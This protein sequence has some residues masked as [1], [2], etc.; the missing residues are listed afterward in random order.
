MCGVEGDASGDKTDDGRRC[1]NPQVSDTVEAF[2]TV[3]LTGK[4]T[5]GETVTDFDNLLEQ[6]VNTAV[7]VDLNRPLLWE[8][9]IDALKARSQPERTNGQ[10]L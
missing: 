10:I 2:V 7:A 3:E 1:A 5:T 8:M 9:T 6:P 4:W